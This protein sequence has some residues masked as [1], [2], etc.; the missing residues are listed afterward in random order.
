MK[1]WYTVQAKNRTEEKARIDRWHS[2]WNGLLTSSP[3][4]SME[5]VMDQLQ[6]FKE[7]VVCS[8]RIWLWETNS[9]NPF[10]MVPS[11]N[12]QHRIPNPKCQ[13]GCYSSMPWVVTSRRSLISI[14]SLQSSVLVF[15]HPYRILSANR[16]SEFRS[17][18]P[19]LATSYKSYC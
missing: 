8:Q 5:F 14:S 18:S 4:P 9:T 1:K 19:P 12:R 15:N 17:P 10:L 6:R 13:T 3:I 7:M 11:P 2:R 16:W